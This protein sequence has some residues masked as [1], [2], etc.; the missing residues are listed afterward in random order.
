MCEASYTVGPQLYQVTCEK[1]GVKKMEPNWD[2]FHLFPLLRHKH[3]FL[4][5]QGIEQFQSW[6]LARARSL[7]G[8]L[9]SFWRHFLFRPFSHYCLTAARQGKSYEGRTRMKK[10]LEKQRWSQQHYFYFLKIFIPI[11]LQISQGTKPCNSVHWL[12]GSTT[13]A[14]VHLT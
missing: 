5:R 7:P 9:C 3:L 11:L 8:W 1:Q 14:Q 6:Y 13:L 2:I 4:P 10:F 12:A